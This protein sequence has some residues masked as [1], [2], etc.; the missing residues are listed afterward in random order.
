MRRIP[1][2][3][4]DAPS[5]ASVDLPQASL[6]AYRADPPP[7][8]GR[9]LVTQPTLSFVRAGIKHLQPHGAAEPAIVPAGAMVAMGAGIHV[10]T[11]LTAGDGRYESTVLSLSPDLLRDLLGAGGA[12]GA[13]ATAARVPAAMAPM[14]DRLQQL[15]EPPIRSAGADLRAREML[16][17]AASAAPI[18]ALLR[19][20]AHRWG[21]DDAERIRAVMQ[22]H[23]LSPLQLPEYAALSAMSLSTFKRRFRDAFDDAPGRWLSR[24][25]LQHARWL[26]L[27]EHSSVTDACY[28]SGFGDLS[29]FTRAFRR[30]FGLSPRAYRAANR[31]AAR[32]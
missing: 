27:V 6:I 12:G 21:N 10:M 1:D 13:E 18:R 24:T 20:E 9:F 30:H 8:P 17:V 23:S 2:A 28:A 29:N 11:E 19:R 26:L 7:P 25:R 3:L 31:H 4:C 32:S 22:A 15:L 5:Q 16:L 14:P